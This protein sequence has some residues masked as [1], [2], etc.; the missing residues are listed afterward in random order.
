MN[1][2]TKKILNIVV[3]VVVIAILVV[4]AFIAVSI[5]LSGN[6]GYTEFFGHARVAVQS[7]SM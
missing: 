7:D 3:N 2:K 5:I 4:V 1:E 6:K